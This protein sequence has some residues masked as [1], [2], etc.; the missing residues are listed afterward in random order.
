MNRF[1]NVI[2][3]QKAFI[4]SRGKILIMKRKEADYFIGKWDVPGGK[5]ESRDNNLF[6]SISREILEEAGLKL[7]KILLILSTSKF[8]GSMGDHPIIFRNIYLCV[9]EGKVKLCNEHSEFLW[10][11]PQDLITYN[12]PDDQD[13]QS[14][15]KRLPDILKKLDDSIDY[16]KIF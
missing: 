15:L 16:S 13:I 4:L 3:G 1:N 8:K 14:V 11:K 5:F 7:T 12:F 10:V 2:I 9:A 6:E